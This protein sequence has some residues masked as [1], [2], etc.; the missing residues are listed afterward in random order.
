MAKVAG[1]YE[2]I[3]GGVSRQPP[4][5]R[6]ES[7]AWEMTNMVADPREGLTRR[8]GLEWAD[9]IGS[10]M[11]ANPAL[12][13]WR[14]QDLTVA[15]TEYSLTYVEAYNGVATSG[16]LVCTNKSTGA[17]LPVVADLTGY[18]TIPPLGPATALGRFSVFAPAQDALALAAR[19]AETDDWA[20]EANQK[21][22]LI[23]IRG[24][25]YSRK[26]RFALI[27]G[28]Q[29]F[30][31]EYT[32]LQASYPLTLDTTDIPSNDPDYTKKVND[33]TNAYNSAVNDWI[34]KALADV[35]PANIANQLA[36]TLL[37]SGFLG[38]DGVVEVVGTNICI[39]DPTIEEVEGDDSGDATLL[40]AVGNTVGSPALLTTY[41]YPGK[42]V[43][44][45]PNENSE[46]NVFYL[47][48]QAKDQSTGKF[49]QVTWEETAGT[50]TSI[51][52]KLVLWFATVHDGVC[53]LVD[54]PAKVRALLGTEFPDWS[55]REAGDTTS[56]PVPEFLS[57]QITCLFTFQ[58]RLGI[59]AGANIALSRPGDYLN[60]W[61]ESVLTVP[62]DDP[63]EFIIIGGEDDTIRRS[64]SYDRNRVLFG[65]KKQYILNGREQMSPQNAT[66][67]IMAEF[68]NAAEVQPVLI[69]NLM[70]YATTGGDGVAPGI[71]QFQPGPI[72]ESPESNEVT[73][74]VRPYLG[75]EVL[76]LIA[77][78]QNKMLF[79]RVSGAPQ[80]LF[81]YQYQD[82]PAGT[83]RLSDAWHRWDFEP[84][85]TLG[86][87]L[88]V[89]T[90]GK[91]LLVTCG[92]ALTAQVSG[93]TS[94]VT[95]YRACR[96][97][98]NEW[99][100][101][102][103][104]M[105]RNQGQTFNLARSHTVDPGKIGGAGYLF[106]VSRDTSVLWGNFGSD[107]TPHPLQV[108]AVSKTTLAGTVVEPPVP[109]AVDS[110][111]WVGHVFESCWTPTSPWIKSREGQP[112]LDGRLTVVTVRPTFKN[113][114]GVKIAVHEKDQLCWDREL[115]VN[116]TP[117]A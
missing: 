95:G 100:G 94:A 39:T 106:R 52:P 108:A 55:E 78:T 81:V 13:G 12:E 54:T 102:Y 86:S 91:G 66:G 65:D 30:W 70:F 59:V 68:R 111:N 18:S 112:V 109:L 47:V 19:V 38:P 26:F 16:D 43:R 115:F 89:A 88:S 105:W 80:S 42:I 14:S 63:V 8:N 25:A 10:Q 29:K 3:L 15:G 74:A 92:K 77:D 1:A 35:Q 21:R 113:T 22:H 37:S 69:G 116:G 57:E 110:G 44:V 64:I 114:G 67:I 71:H 75:G 33:R 28:N 50:S 7:Q 99:T 96:V 20:T 46:G 83:E 23:W 31:V 32:T 103:L 72:T 82:N 34:G 93:G 104:D 98:L 117:E 79:A 61:R 17:M 48:A 49:T 4:E 27:R 62:A 9:A 73:Q 51:D 107:A 5:R 60:F 84:A 6:R 40:R 2:S 90:T 97:K 41:G 45:R 24:G 85:E 101:P 53:Y 58:D 56:S 87:I 36:A 76:E 11:P